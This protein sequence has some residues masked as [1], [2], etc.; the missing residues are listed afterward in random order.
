MLWARLKGANPFMAMW[1]DVYEVRKTEIV[2][3]DI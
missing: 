1:R 3:M 2:L